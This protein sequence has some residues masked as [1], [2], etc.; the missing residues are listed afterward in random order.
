[1]RLIH[2]NSKVSSGSS[3]YFLIDYREFLQCCNYNASA[4]VECVTQV[5]GSLSLTYGFD[6]AKCVVE[7][8][9]GRLQLRIENGAVGNNNNAAENRLVIFVKQRS[10]A[11]CGPSDLVGL[12][13]TCAVLNKVVS[14]CAVF[15]NICDEL[16]NHI[17][18]MITRENKAFLGYGLF[19]AV[20]ANLLLGCN[21]Q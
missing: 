16:A 6:R 8:G 9:N 13:R 18:L 3:V 19:L 14:A 15:R 11:I 5:A 21:L 4:V 10:K 17:E 12:A 1:M 7:A 20:V 2:D